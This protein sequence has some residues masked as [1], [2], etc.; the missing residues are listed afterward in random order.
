[1]AL[2]ELE[3]EFKTENP[4]TIT[5]DWTHAGVLGSGDMEVLMR[6][7]ENGGIASIKIKTKVHGFDE[8]WKNVLERFVQTQRL[9]NIVIEINDNAATPPVVVRRLQQALENAE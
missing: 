1:M 8:V 6:P 3:F 4:K 2:T 7:C 9:G 5:S